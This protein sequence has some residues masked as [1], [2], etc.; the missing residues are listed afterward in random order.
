[1]RSETS[2]ITK[3]KNS[4]PLNGSRRNYSD[5]FSSRF[6]SVKDQLITQPFANVNSSSERFNFSFR[7]L[8]TFGISF[9]CNP[10]SEK[11]ISVFNSLTRFSFFSESIHSASDVYVRKRISR[12]RGRDGDGLSTNESKDTKM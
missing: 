3:S 12:R 4:Q 7:F 1:M 5:M 8:L 2:F 6:S 9:V 11:K 10:F